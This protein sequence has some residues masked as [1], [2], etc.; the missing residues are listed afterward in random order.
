MSQ[1]RIPDR[2][3][4]KPGELM[5]GNFVCPCCGFVTLEEEAP[6]TY[7]ICRMCGWEDDPV[8]FADVDYRGGANGESLREARAEFQKRLGEHPGWAEM[9]RRP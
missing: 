4:R 9:A 7:E 8:Q 5:P 1:M 2:F 3:L 6:G